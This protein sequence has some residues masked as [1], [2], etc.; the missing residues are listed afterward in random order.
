MNGIRE[1][2]R[3]YYTR[4]TAALGWAFHPLLHVVLAFV[5]AILAY[6]IFHVEEA[7]ISLGFALLVFII[8]SLRE[9]YSLHKEWEF[10]RELLGRVSHE[11][12][13]EYHYEWLQFHYIVGSRAKHDEWIRQYTLVAKDEVLKIKNLAFGATGEGT[14]QLPF[15]ALG[16]NA[17]PRTSDPKYKKSTENAPDIYIVPYASQRTSD[18]WEGSVYFDPPLSNVIFPMNITGYWYGLWNP[19][20]LKGHDTCKVELTRLAEKFEVLVTAPDNHQLDFDGEPQY[21]NGATLKDHRVQ[22]SERGRAQLAVEFE[23][24]GSGNYIVPVKMASK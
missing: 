7:V 22:V 16:V 5:A 8:L 20:R 24:A 12:E 21:P 10:Y 6:F 14:G 15:S 1:S 23:N 9:Y 18:H 17:F 11:P 3:Y 13:G 4:I 2:I 19:L